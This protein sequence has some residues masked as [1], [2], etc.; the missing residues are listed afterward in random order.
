[1]N[2][3]H[4][5][6]NAMIALS[7]PSGKIWSLVM[8]QIQASILPETSAVAWHEFVRGPMSTAECLRVERL[9]NGRVVPLTRRTAELAA[10]IFNTTGRRRAST[11]DC[12]IAATAIER[13]AAL[14]TLNVGDFNRFESH[15]LKLLTP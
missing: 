2:R 1:M 11:A 15:G 14:V 5:D 7:D 4:L 3:L 13:N 9:L 10:T 12:L 6:A 8:E